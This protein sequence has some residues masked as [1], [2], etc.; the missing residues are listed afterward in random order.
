MSGLKFF[1][2]TEFFYRMKCSPM[3]ATQKR[4]ILYMILQTEQR[5]LSFNKVLMKGLFILNKLLEP[6]K[7]KWTRYSSITIHI[8]IVLEDLY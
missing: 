1:I 6:N 5:L 7:N 8:F 4:I 2:L 3:L